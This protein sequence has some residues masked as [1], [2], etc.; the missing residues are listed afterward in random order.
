MQLR[1]RYR[2]R[3]E[4][5]APVKST[6]YEPNWFRAV[7]TV[8]RRVGLKR[9]TPDA[10]DNQTIRRQ[11]LFQSRRDLVEA[12]DHHSSRAEGFCDLHVHR[13]E[14]DA[15]FPTILAISRN[16][17]RSYA[18]SIQTGCTRSQFSRTAVSSSTAEKRNPP[19]PDTGQFAALKAGD[20]VGRFGASR[21][22]RAI[23]GTG[24]PASPDWYRISMTEHEIDGQRIWQQCPRPT[25]KGGVRQFRE[26]RLRI[27]IAIGSMVLIAAILLDAFEAVLLPRRVSRGYPFLRLF[28]RY[29]WRAW[30]RIAMLAPSSRNHESTLGIFGPLALLVLYVA[31]ATGLVMSFG[32][33]HWALQT[34]LTGGGLSPSLGTCLYFSGTTFFT[35][36]YGDATPTGGL[37]RFL[38]V[39]ESGLGFGFLAM[40]IG[41][42]PVLAQAFSRR[43]IV[44][45]LLDARGGS[46]PSA[47]QILIRG[48]RP[49][50]DAMTSD[51]RNWETWCA[52]LLESCLSFPMLAYYRSQ[53][54]NQSWLAALTAIL[55]TCALAICRTDDPGQ[56]Q[57]RLTFAIARHAAV[58][59]TLIFRITPAAPEPERI[60]PGCFDELKELLNAAGIPLGDDPK[61]ELRLAELRKMYE[62]FVNG[63]SRYFLLP[64]PEFNRRRPTA[65]NWQTS[66]WMPPTRGILD[67]PIV[68]RGDHFE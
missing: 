26:A 2:V 31:W 29:T 62:P 16:R 6:P 53:H 30:R 15:R 12:V 42:H 39:L 50:P 21:I 24:V 36:G 54:D 58:D 43:E 22:W 17:T 51:F 64:L 59:L 37:G 14:F 13:A 38:A 33:L 9:A 7:S 8:H 66:A 49:S 25:L 56:H 55:D 34:P 44:I 20:G 68:E 1:H 35:L 60:G 67:L 10:H 5:Q 27:V 57:A 19:W 4:I 46:P 40:V 65:D 28:Y 47:A 41:Y 32:L 11:S 52:E 3:I 61:V 45:S 23:N 63:L 18:T 48:A